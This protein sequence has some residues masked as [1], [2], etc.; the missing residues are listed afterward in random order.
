MTITYRATTA[1][2]KDLK[3]LLKRFR[4][5]ADDLEVV[6]KNAIEVYHLLKID[7]QS[8][9]PIPHF[10]DDKVQVCKVKK[11]ACKALKGRGVKSGMR[12][13]YAYWPEDSVVDLIEIYFKGEKDNEDQ[14]RIKGHIKKKIREI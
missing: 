2:E 13:I 10:C 6:K 8:V 3:R 1:F 12:L 4:S 9:F 5:L 7:N 14:E 11:F